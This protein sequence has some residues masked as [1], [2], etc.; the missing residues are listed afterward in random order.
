MKAARVVLGLLAGFLL[1]AHAPA[2]HAQA[3]KGLEGTWK[4]NAA[5]ST[6]SPRMACQP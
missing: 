4:L 6:F 2:A 3:P 5:K 1:L